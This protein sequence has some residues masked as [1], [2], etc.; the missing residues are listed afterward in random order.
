[1]ATYWDQ[2]AKSFRGA[3]SGAVDAETLRG[4]HAVRPGR[5]FLVLARQLVVLAAAVYVILRWGGLAYAWIPASVVIGFVIFDFTVL[6]HGMLDCHRT[7]RRS[8]HLLGQRFRVLMPDLPG[9]GYSGRPDA[10]YTLEWFADV[11]GQWM[12]QWSIGTSVW[13]FFAKKP[14]PSGRIWRRVL[15]R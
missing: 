12:K 1:M 7:W 6:L 11:I 8:A 14:Q 5:H 10:P 2:A 4:L 13:L 3:L 15:W 9:F